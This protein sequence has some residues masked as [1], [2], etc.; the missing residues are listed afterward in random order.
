MS[1][2]YIYRLHIAIG[3]KYIAG[4]GT[5]CLYVID[6]VF[7]FLRT[8]KLVFLYNVVVVVVYGACANETCLAPSIHHQFV[9]IIA[10]LVFPE[11]DIALDKGVQVFLRLFVHLFAVNI[12]I[13]RK[14]Y[15]AF[16]NVEERI[17]IA[18]RFFFRFL[19]VEHIVWPGSH[20][21]C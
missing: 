4:L 11:K 9:Y 3:K 15:F 1:Q 10:A 5:C 8:G 14:V 18:L 16:G 17:W 7:L 2:Q 13:I 19:A 6:A 12:Y 21:W 20:F